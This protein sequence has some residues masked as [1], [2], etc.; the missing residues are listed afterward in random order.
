MPAP[1][2]VIVPTLNAEASLG[3]TLAALMEGVDAGLIAELIVSDGGSTDGTL[4]LADAWGANI[5]NGSPSR[6]GQL[7]RGCEA[8]RAKWF[9]VL[10]ADTV[11]SAGWSE[12]VTA[13]LG[14]RGAAYFKLKFDRGGRVV[15]LWANARARFLSL[16]Y[17]DQGLLVRR[18]LYDRVGGYPDVPLMEDVALARALRG[19]L[20][21]LDA[22]AVTS[23][24][25]YRRDGWLRRG[26]RN[27]WT[28]ARYFAGADPE[29][30]AAA[31]R[32]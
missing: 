19:E 5:I 6:G 27:L 25:K 2:S 11:L 8:A 22:V 29:V 21:S 16:P 4:K 1:I 12:P 10:H 31:Y 17:G 32:R 20:T 15:A 18:D 30:L 7:C 3:P 9:L 26:A 28:L 14:K 13:H 24:E 23:S